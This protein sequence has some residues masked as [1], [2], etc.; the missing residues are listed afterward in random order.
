M[1]LIADQVD[2]NAEMEGKKQT[3]LK[4][5]VF[6][7]GIAG[8][9]K[10]N[11]RKADWN[12]TECRTNL[13]KGSELEAKIEIL[14]ELMREW[15]EQVTRHKCRLQERHSPTQS[16]LHKEKKVSGGQ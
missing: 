12:K 15:G 5:K 8:K 16:N 3:G 7:V 14:T 9:K 10:T 13:N 11:K 4:K 6:I 2:P 1:S